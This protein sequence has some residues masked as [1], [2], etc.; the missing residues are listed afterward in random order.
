M[1]QLNIAFLDK[2]EAYLEQLKGYL[3]HKNEA[4]FR[5]WTFQ[6]GAAFLEE[7]QEHTAF[8]AVVMT[9]DF[10]EELEGYVLGA[11]KI[12][13]CEGGRRKS[14]NAEFHVAKYQSAE[15]LFCQISA[16]LWQDE[17]EQD[18]L[19][20]HTAELIGVYSPVH[21]ESQMLFSMTMAQIL[22]ENQTVLYV[23]LMEHSG[24]CYLTN[25][26]ASEDIGDLVYGMMQKENDFT[27][28]LHRVRKKYKN[29]DY[30][31]PVANPEHLS[32]ISKALFEKLLIALK[33]QSGYDVVMV[34]F[35]MV[36]LGFAEMLPVFGSF[37]C[38]GK[39]GLVNRKRMEEFLE[40]LGKE[41]EYV[42]Q[43]MRRLL[44]PEPAVFTAEKGVMESSLYGG[45]GDYIRGCLYG[46]AEVGR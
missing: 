39:E 12:L 36:F 13:L 35:G 16:V 14:L 46:G 26:K 2:E 6:N 1:I 42:T 31:P 32:E 34:D 19:P 41:G 43:H 15:K 28:G 21:H 33:S 8:D 37:Y 29:F 40:Y 18:Y 20:E 5:I 45:M 25:E 4:F 23:N 9:E 11:K 7:W 27:A 38:L 17:K 10:W 22:G 30:I 44:L 24:F 3:I